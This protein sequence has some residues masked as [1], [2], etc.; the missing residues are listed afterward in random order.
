MVTNFTADTSNNADIV[1]FRVP[2]FY[3]SGPGNISFTDID[4]TKPYL[5]AARGGANC[6]LIVTTDCNPND[7]EIKTV[8]VNGLTLS[9]PYNDDS[10]RTN[11]FVIEMD[12]SA[13]RRNIFN[14][15]NIECRDFNG[16]IY[17]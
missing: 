9:T 6:H 17:P 11:V 13:Y 14:A 10:S 15:S 1:S 16:G 8:S 7:G 4:A 5:L 3:Y 12:T 2:Y